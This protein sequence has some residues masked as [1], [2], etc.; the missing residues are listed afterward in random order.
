MNPDELCQEPSY[1]RVLINHPVPWTYK[2]GVIYDA[3]DKEV[4][5]DNTVTSSIF[6]LVWAIYCDILSSQVE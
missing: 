4:I 6:D 1:Y 3:N 5:K 2:S